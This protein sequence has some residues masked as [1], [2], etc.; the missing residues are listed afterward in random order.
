MNMF[1][2]LEGRL[3]ELALLGVA[4]L[5]VLI[6]E[7]V[8]VDRLATSAY[9]QV[10]AMLLLLTGRLRTVALGEVTT[11]DHEVLDHT[12]EGRVLVTEALLAGSQSTIGG[13]AYVE[14]R[15]TLRAEQLA[16]PEV[17]SSLFQ[18]HMSA[19]RFNCYCFGGVAARTSGTVLPYKPITMRPRDSSP[20]WMSK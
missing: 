6:L 11:L 19:K 5:E 3:T 7:L 10:S 2:K 9:M 18:R 16:I 17:L 1:K 14:V 12:V 8:A 4:E 20:C 13:L 15:Q